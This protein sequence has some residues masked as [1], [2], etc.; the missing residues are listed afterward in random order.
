VSEERNWEEEARAGGWVPEPEGIPEEKRVDAKTFVER[1]EKI[2]GVMK[3]KV[4]RLETK[5]EELARTNA[6]FQIYHQ[7][8]L[9]R[10]Q[11]EA[12]KRIADLKKERA[13]AITEGDGQRFTK[14]ENELEELES[15]AQPKGR[16][17]YNQLAN[18]WVRDN[19][20]YNTNEKLQ[21]YADGVA[22]KIHNAG[23]TGQAYFNELTRRVKETFPEEFKN[24]NRERTSSVET[25]TVREQDDPKPKSWNA[26]PKEA[27][28]QC[29]KF[30]KNI[31][32]FT[33]EQFLAEYDWE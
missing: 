20:W 18:N 13:E 12:E 22:E 28:A 6:E 4:E 33:A 21:A 26:L 30:I 9:E 23:Y 31:P 8:T 27:K 25:D 10:T 32:G 24:P 17:E 19:Q 29:E 1:G 14:I 2:A 7:K 11:K 16:D 3:S 15:S 5:V